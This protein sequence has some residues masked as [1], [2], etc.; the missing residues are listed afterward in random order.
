M[1][2][3]YERGVAVKTLRFSVGRALALAVAVS[4]GGAWARD[5]PATAVPASDGSKALVSGVGAPE[6][7]K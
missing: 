1:S 7:V 2:K 5:V 4:V 6:R 3:C